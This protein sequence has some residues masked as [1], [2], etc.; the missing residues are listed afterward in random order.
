MGVWC[1]DLEEASGRPALEKWPGPELRGCGLFGG[2]SGPQPGTETGWLTHSASV[3]FWSSIC[4]SGPVAA[5]LRVHTQQQGGR[6]AGDSFVIHATLGM[7]LP[8]ARM[9]WRGLSRGTHLT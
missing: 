2:G 1:R 9:L 3:R 4:V 6:H 7:Q 5:A 8:L